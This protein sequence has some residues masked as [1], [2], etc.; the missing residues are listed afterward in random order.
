MKMHKKS[1]FDGQT[2]CCV[3]GCCCTRSCPSKSL[4]SKNVHAEISLSAVRRDAKNALVLADA[5]RFLNRRPD[6]GSSRWTEQD[7]FLGRKLPACGN[8]R[9]VLDL[10]DVVVDICIQNRRHEAWT[11]TDQLMGSG[12]AARQDGGT[13]RLHDKNAQCRQQ[14]AKLFSRSGN[15]SSGAAG[16]DEHIHSPFHLLHDLQRR[17]SPMR[18]WIGGIFKLKGNVAA[19][20]SYSQL[21]RLADR[22]RHPLRCRRQHDL[23]S[24]SPQDADP[25]LAHIV[26]HDE[27]GLVSSRRRIHGDADARVAAGRLDDRPPRLQET[28]LLRLQHH[29]GGGPVLHASAR[30]ELFQLHVHL[31]VLGTD[32]P[33]EPDC[34]GISDQLSD[35]IHDSRRHWHLPSLKFQQFDYYACYR[36]NPGFSNAQ[37]HPKSIVVMEWSKEQKR[38]PGGSLFPC[39]I[40][41]G[42]PAL[43]SCRPSISGFCKDSWTYEIAT[44]PNHHVGLFK[45]SIR[46]DSNL[47]G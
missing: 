5:A 36:N 45:T 17:R 3:Q 11:R 10:H 42:G 32:E 23:G 7:A 26:R 41:L 15:R 8:G 27:N 4:E 12:L 30:I 20:N 43:T 25:L 29:I 21:L 47:N 14:L 44:F 40:R 6:G 46:I 38:D 2:F 16:G 35:G 1:A 19:F 13:L 18:I 24:V 9:T 37:P 39:W 31:G 34:R 22:S 28:V 33:I